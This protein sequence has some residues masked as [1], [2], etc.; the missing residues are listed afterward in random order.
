MKKIISGYILESVSFNSI[1]KDKMKSKVLVSVRKSLINCRNEFNQNFCEEDSRGMKM[2]KIN[3]LKLLAIL[4]II[5]LMLNSQNIGA[6]PSQSLTEIIIDGE[7]SDWQNVDPVLVDEPINASYP[8]DIQSG[9][10]AFNETHFFIRIDY[11]QPYSDFIDPGTGTP[12]GFESLMSN[13]TIQNSLGEV[14]VVMCQVIYD[15]VDQWAFTGVI[16]GRDLN[17]PY[18]TDTDKIIMH[19]GSN[20]GS[21]DTSTNKTMEYTVLLADLNISTSSVINATLWHFDQAPAGS[22]S[23]FNYVKAATIINFRLGSDGPDTNP[24]NTDTNTNTN[25][26]TNTGTTDNPSIELPDN[27][28]MIAI[29][30]TG[31]VVAVAIITRSGKLK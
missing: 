11:A 10:F 27:L 23:M 19:D 16:E 22:V 4:L 14:F 6:Y 24:T 15:T 17:S 31:S 29:V 7:I 12:I 13:I 28:V 1:K 21:V 9:F 20:W 25:T 3:I 26:N 5:N 30:I 2:K 18:N 8:L